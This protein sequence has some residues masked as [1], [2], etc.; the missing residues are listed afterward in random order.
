MRHKQLFSTLK[1]PPKPNADSPR[2][3]WA[4]NGSDGLYYTFAINDTHVIDPGHTYYAPELEFKQV[5]RRAASGSRRVELTNSGKLNHSHDP[6]GKSCYICLTNNKP[7]LYREHAFA[8]SKCLLEVL[9]ED[10]ETFVEV[11]L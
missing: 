8:P 9:L 3:E 2:E 1:L 4:R 5:V 10:R 7:G 11:R 6:L